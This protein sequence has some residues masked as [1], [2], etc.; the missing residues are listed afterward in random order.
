M[1]TDTSGSFW[2]QQGEAAPSGH[3]PDPA[4]GSLLSVGGCSQFFQPIRITAEFNWEWMTDWS[5][6][7]S[8]SCL[9]SFPHFHCAW[10][11][12]RGTNKTKTKQRKRAL[13]S[14]PRLYK[15]PPSL[16]ELQPGERFVTWGDPKIPQVNSLRCSKKRRMIH[17][18]FKPVAKNL[19][20]L[21]GGELW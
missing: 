2:S 1:S 10:I 15:K 3:T 11:I 12:S 16:Q 18:F 13:S 4:C 9:S 14:F 7:L 6:G 19:T 5:V 17:L 20:G 21:L 8:S